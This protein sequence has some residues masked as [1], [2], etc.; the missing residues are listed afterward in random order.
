MKCAIS[1]KWLTIEQNGWKFGTSGP[2]NSLC[3]VIFG[4]GHLS[5]VWG[6]SVHFA[7]FPMLRFSKGYCCPSFHP[8]STKHYWKQGNQGRIQAITI[9]AICQIIK[10]YGTLKI[11]YL[12]YIASIHKSILVSSDKWSSRASRPWVFGSLGFFF[13][14][15]ILNCWFIT[16]FSLSLTYRTMNMVLKTASCRVKRMKIWEIVVSTLPYVADNFKTLLILQFSSN[17]SQTLSGHWIPW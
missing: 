1:W 4:S 16:I 2:R 8:N 11:S 9:L 7:K 17:V 6:H 12:S 15:Q 10:V 14:F 3:R 13:F 5:S